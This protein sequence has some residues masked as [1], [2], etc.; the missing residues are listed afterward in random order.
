MRPAL[1]SHSRATL[2]RRCALLHLLIV[3]TGI[4]A[5]NSIAVAQGFG[6]LKMEGPLERTH[7]PNVYLPAA[8]VIAQVVAQRSDAQNIQQRLRYDMERALNAPRRSSE[9][10]RGSEK[11]GLV[12]ARQ[13]AAS[14]SR[15]GSSSRDGNASR[16][17]RRHRRRAWISTRA[18]IQRRRQAHE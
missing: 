2:T 9:R 12:G 10:L 15:E 6:I 1:P 3:V 8:T 18:G 5:V 7:P 16:A 13:S 11:P 14:R 4:L 17:A